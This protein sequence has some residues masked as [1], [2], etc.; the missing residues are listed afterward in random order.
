VDVFVCLVRIVA[1]QQTD[2]QAT[3]RSRAPRCVL[4]HAGQP[5]AN[6]HSVALRNAAT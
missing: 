6:E 3:G 4:H 5:A 2:R 1:R